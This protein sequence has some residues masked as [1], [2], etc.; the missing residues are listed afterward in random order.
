RHIGEAGLFEL[1]PGHGLAHIPR[2]IELTPGHRVLGQLN[3]PHPVGTRSFSAFCS[4]LASALMAS[5]PAPTAAF[6]S[7]ASMS[8]VMFVPIFTNASIGSF[9]NRHQFGSGSAVSGRPC[10]SLGR[11]PTGSP[12]LGPGNALDFL[13]AR[14]FRRGD[15]EALE[16]VYWAY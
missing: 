7:F 3:S 16:E 4:A 13:S 1:A 10:P 5:N 15:R 9:S 12:S 2:Q 11:G 6:S 14:A 8:R